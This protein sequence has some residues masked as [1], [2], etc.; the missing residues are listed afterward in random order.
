MPA[1]FF[2][3]GVF[4][5]N[6]PYSPWEKYWYLWAAVGLGLLTPFSSLIIRR[7]RDA[8][9]S[10][11]YALLVIAWW[12][13]WP[14]MHGNNL[15]SNSDIFLGGIIIGDLAFVFGCVALCA[16]PSH[17][18]GPAWSPDGIWKGAGLFILRVVIGTVVM[19]VLFAMF[20]LI[21]EE[22]IQ[23]MG[24]YGLTDAMVRMFLSDMTV[25]FGIQLPLIPVFMLQSRVEGRSVLEPF[26]PGKE[27]LTDTLS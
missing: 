25:L 26:R 22:M 15:L 8:N 19:A 1:I 11:L 24:G 5:D 9:K 14:T 18:A 16:M 3:V 20:S 10:S 2:L 21:F 7:I 27:A 13:L 23:D 4:G 12:F 17:S 6:V